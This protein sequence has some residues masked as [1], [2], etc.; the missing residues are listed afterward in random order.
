TGLV[1][2]LDERRQVLL[3]RLDILAEPGLLV[4]VGPLLLGRLGGPDRDR[5]ALGGRDLAPRARFAIAHAGSLP[6]ATRRRTVSPSRRTGGDRCPI[7]CTF[8][9]L[10]ANAGRAVGQRPADSMC[11]GSPRSLGSQ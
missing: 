2:V 4:P 3:V 5:P 1:R 8:A 10:A 6:P 7:G 9:S 11:V